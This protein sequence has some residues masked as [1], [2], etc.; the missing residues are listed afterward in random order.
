[1]GSTLIGPLIDRW[2]SEP[3]MKPILQS[4]TSALQSG[5]AEVI[6]SHDQYEVFNDPRAVRCQSSHT[7]ANLIIDYWYISQTQRTR[8]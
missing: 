6:N 1:M 4:A 8:F 3:F 5:S 2:I 7:L